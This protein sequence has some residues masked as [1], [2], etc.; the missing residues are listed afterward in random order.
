MTYA[1]IAHSFYN[2]FVTHRIRFPHSQN[3]QYTKKRFF[4]CRKIRRGYEFKAFSTRF[5]DCLLLYD[6][7]LSMCQF[8]R[9]SQKHYSFAAPRMRKMADEGVKWRKII[10]KTQRVIHRVIMTSFGILAAFSSD[11][12][13]SSFL[14]TL[15]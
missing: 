9:K 1:I 13:T 14:H 11:S 7:T 4:T 12:S 6:E 3:I 8:L 15:Y 10:S 5:R 2:N